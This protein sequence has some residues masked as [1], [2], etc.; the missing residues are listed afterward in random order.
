MSE[1]VSEPLPRRTNRA[2]FDQLFAEG[3]EA[4]ADGSY[5]IQV[6]PGEGGR[7]WGVSA[8]L[9]PD[10]RAAASLETLACEA[11]A[12]AGDGHW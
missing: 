9:R 12:I 8:L 4:L 7:R 5:G 11:A 2:T 3:A 6:V 1:P 10:S